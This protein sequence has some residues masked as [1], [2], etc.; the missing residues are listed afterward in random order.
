QQPVRVLVRPEKVD[1]V[2]GVHVPLQ[3]ME[4]ILQRLGFQV[5]VEGDGAWDVLPPVFR[6]D[7]SIPEDVAEEVG[8]IYGYDRVPATLPGARR[9]AW[10][11]ATASQDRRLDAVRHP[12]AAAGY[13]EAITASLVAGELL[14]RLDLGERAMRAVD[15]A[16]GR[17]R[18]A[19]VPCG[20]GAA[21]PRRPL[22]PGDAGRQAGRV[23]G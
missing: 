17:R 9:T 15:P 10:H 4:D 14:N 19:R 12:M 1:A 13:T 6:L 22:R 18:R 5:R 11:P 16:D 23:R 20:A 7:V 8:R 2:L 3:E 21:L